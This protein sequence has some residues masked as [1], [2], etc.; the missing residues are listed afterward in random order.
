M[1]AVIVILNDY[2]PKRITQYNQI[3]LCIKCLVE[4]I[5]YNKRS[6]QMVVQTVVCGEPNLSSNDTN[7]NIFKYVPLMD[8]KYVPLTGCWITNY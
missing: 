8:E 6:S 2:F 3:A 4:E 1:S 7:F 5:K